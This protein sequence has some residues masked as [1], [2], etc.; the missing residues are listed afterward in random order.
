MI[1]LGHRVTDNLQP[2]IITAK[3][4]GKIYALDTGAHFHGTLTGCIV[5]PEPK[6]FQTR[7]KESPGLFVDSQQED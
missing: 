5:G 2:E 3:G 7:K 4:T 6:F 1:Y